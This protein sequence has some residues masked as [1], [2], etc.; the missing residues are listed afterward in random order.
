MLKLICQWL[1]RNIIEHSISMFVLCVCDKMGSHFFSS[2]YFQWDIGENLWNTYRKMCFEESGN[3]QKRNRN[4]RWKSSFRL[5]MDEKWRWD[6]IVC[7]LGFCQP[8]EKKKRKHSTNTDSIRFQCSLWPTKPFSIGLKFPNGRTHTD[9]TSTRKQAQIFWIVT[10]NV[11]QKGGKI[12][13]FL[14]RAI[15]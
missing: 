12:D 10:S 11:S 13:K 1:I 6:S 8:A 3:A 14:W 4:E 7:V 5:E 9:T 2:A 15:C